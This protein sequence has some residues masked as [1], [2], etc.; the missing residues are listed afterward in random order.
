MVSI[1]EYRG[2]I[3]NWKSLCSELG[4]STAISREEREKAIIVKAYEKWGHDIADHLY[5][6]FAFS[7]VDD[8]TGEIFCVRDQFGTKPF[9]YY[10]TADGRLLASLSIRKIM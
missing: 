4:V 9:Y 8:A 5:G 3:R 6:M 10:L 1:F 7:L 2:H